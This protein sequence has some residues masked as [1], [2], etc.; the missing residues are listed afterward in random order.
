[1][2][3]VVSRISIVDFEIYEEAGAIVLGI[4]VREGGGLRALTIQI[5]EP[6]SDLQDYDDG[7]YLELDDKAFYGGV[8]KFEYDERGAVSDWCSIRRRAAELLL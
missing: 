6:A 1:M 5:A 3:I 7:I 2:N 8:T 4:R